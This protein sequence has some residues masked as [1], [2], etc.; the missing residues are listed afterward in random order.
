M[1]NKMPNKE[2]CVRDYFGKM[3]VV[4][5]GSTVVIASHPGNRMTIEFIA[6]NQVSPEDVACVAWFNER[7]DLCRDELPLEC[8]RLAWNE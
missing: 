2:F 8:L 4:S 5:I 3:Q 7:G 6:D 1:V